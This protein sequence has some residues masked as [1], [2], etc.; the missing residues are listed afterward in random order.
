[1]TFSGK[2]ITSINIV[3]DFE[4]DK[5][6]PPLLLDFENNADQFIIDE[7][8]K[9]PLVKT[10]NDEVL[11]KI[12]NI[13]IT[14]GSKIEEEIKIHSVTII[15]T[16]KLEDYL[17]NLIDIYYLPLYVVQH[18]DTLSSICHKIYCDANYEQIVKY[19]FGMKLDNQYLVVR[20]NEKIR[21][22]K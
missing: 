7:L 11:K 18:G 20:P 21:I 5:S 12:N 10:N 14:Y 22:K 1:M 13:K 8:N 9:S 15:P 2:D 3:K 4:L 19:N 6:I 17:I 16:K